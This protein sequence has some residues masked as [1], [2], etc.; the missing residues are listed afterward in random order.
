[1][2]KLFY[3]LLALP[4]VFAAC[5][6]TEEPKPQIEK[7]AVLTLTSNA[8]MDFTAEGGK[9]V[10]TYTAEMKEVTREAAPAT[11][12]A[13]CEADWVT[14]L[15]VAENITFTVA[16]NEGEARETKIVATFADK[17]FEVAV[18]QAKKEDKPNNSPV[19]EA[20]TPTVEYAWNTIMGEVEYKL[21]NPVAG[22]EVAAKST[23]SWISQVQVRDGK[24]LFAMDEN[25]GD[26]REG[27][28]T[29][30]YGPMPA[31]EFIVKQG[32]YVAPDPVIVVDQ[33]AI[34]FDAEGGS[35]SF[36]Y[37]VENPVEG[38]EIEAN[39]DADWITDLAAA[40]GTVSFTV[41]KNEGGLREDKI[42][43]T[44]G[45]ITAEVV[46]KQLVSD[47]DPNLNYSVF[48]VI[49]TWANMEQEGKQWD[50]TFVE[51][52]STLGDMQTVISFYQEEANIQHLNSGNYSVANGT[53]LVNSYTQ[54]GFSV[55][56]GNSSEATDIINADFEVI[57]DTDA[58]VITIKGTFQAGNNSISLRY[59]GAIRGMDISEPTTGAINVTNWA[60]FTGKYWNGS[61]NDSEFMFQ[62]RST[63]GSV[64]VMFD[65]YASPKVS[66]KIASEGTYTITTWEA[67]NS[68]SGDY[69][70]VM[71][72][73]K[74]T[75]N[76]IYGNLS[77]GTLTVEH[78]D[79]GYN[80]TFDFVDTLGRHFIGSYSGALSAGSTVGNP[81][82]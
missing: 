79:G 31:I 1:M 40:N 36:T 9:G 77:E 13:T 43:L 34:E 51:H 74:I 23:T 39:T 16:A 6:Q 48:G 26:A 76:S 49:E 10:I 67:R 19:F 72:Q 69:L 62:G 17:S 33:S 12:E 78:I 75:Y 58:H 52:H 57:A 63:D 22:V 44:Y 28:I 46:V 24:I 81:A 47:Y 38:V 3:L 18:K 35:G 14:D 71:D 82:N 45:Q 80:I 25:K 27:K 20:V 5:E 65:C 73:S 37:T 4:L 30:T 66:N 41:T 21:E 55:Y 64:E 68:D 54:N 7:E 15:V 2:K 29:A 42:I 61:N 50:I 53:I 59:T 32:A 60:T 11:V 56:R 8:T 70:Y